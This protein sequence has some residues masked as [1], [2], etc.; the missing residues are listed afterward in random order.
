M[1]AGPPTY[2]RIPPPA[3]RRKQ[4]PQRQS[5]HGQGSNARDRQAQRSEG[6][7]ARR[8][9]ESARWHVRA[10]VGHSQSGP[11]QEQCE[12][13]RAQ[14]VALILRAGDEHAWS[15]RRRNG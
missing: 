3:A 6:C 13:E 9:H 1:M 2:S 10:E 14:V 4:R 5:S 7:A 11:P 15:G 8:I 12:R